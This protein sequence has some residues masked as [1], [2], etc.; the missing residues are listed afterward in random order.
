LRKRRRRGPRQDL[1][2]RLPDELA[3][4]VADE[5]EVGAVDLDVAAMIVEEGYPVPRPLEDGPE[6]PPP[7]RIAGTVRHGSSLG[8]AR[9]E[10]RGTAGRGQRYGLG[11]TGLPLART[12]K[13][14]GA[15]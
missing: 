7:V 5:L 3:L 1:L 9:D 15:P 14:M 10:R 11:F 4:L 2:D 6:H 13:W 8:V 12:S